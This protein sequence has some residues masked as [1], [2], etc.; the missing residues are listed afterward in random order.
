MAII[1]F[2]LLLLFVAAP[3]QEEAPIV[4]TAPESP[5]H[6]APLEMHRFPQRDFP[7][8]RYGAKTGQVGAT[9]EAFR[10]AMAACNKAGG[11]RVVVPAGT[12]ETGPIHFR[13]NCELHLEEGAE[14]VFDDDLKWYRPAVQVSWEGMECMNWSPLIYAFECENIAVSGKGKLTARLDGWRKWFPRTE[15]FQRASKQLYAMAATDVPVAM[16]DM[17]ALEADMRP[18]FLHFNRCTNVQL[19]GFEV[20]STPFWTIHLLLCKDVWV[21]DL[22]EEAAYGYNQDGIDV[23]MTR[24]VLIERCRFNQGDDAV[25]LKSGRNRDGWRLDTPTEDVVIRN[26]HIEMGGS[27]FAAGSELSGGIRRVHV[28][29]CTAR[30]LH[31]IAFVKT[32]E[33]RGGV[34]EDILVEKVKAENAQSVFM[35]LTNLFFKWKAVPTFERRYTKIHGITLRDVTLGEASSIVDIVGDSHEPVRDITL[36]R[37]H[38]G[39]V[40][41]F[42]MRLDNAR[43]IR[44]NQVG[45]DRVDIREVEPLFH[46]ERKKLRDW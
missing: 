23:E 31:N 29:D 40:H 2:L 30:L 10:K 1:T 15:N 45:C 39:T 13:S 33:R 36:E 8:T 4:V 25:A 3:V 43:D 6:F 5:F 28:H 11:G 20:H 17:V 21:H 19:S 46:V 37:V 7:I 27:F 26:C 41:A 12:W 18:H 32:N 14:L 22:V 42:E 35:V 44:M 16:R 38:V 9:T 34:V 24:H